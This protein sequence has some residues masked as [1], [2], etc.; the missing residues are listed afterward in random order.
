MFNLVWIFKTLAACS[1]Y[2][3]IF[4]YY[5]FLLF[6]LVFS[7]LG[8]KS[9][10]AGAASSCVSAKPATTRFISFYR[11]VYMTQDFLSVW[12]QNIYPW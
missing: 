12:A 6:H 10:R 9:V 3:N 2:I 1:Y 11:C 5:L 7:Q 4:S 8:C